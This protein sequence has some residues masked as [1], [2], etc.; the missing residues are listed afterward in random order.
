[1]SAGAAGRALRR[2]AG[3][4]GD[5]ARHVEVVDFGETQAAQLGVQVGGLKKLRK[6]SPIAATRAARSA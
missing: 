2:L 3:Q 5:N 4:A 6:G 1:M